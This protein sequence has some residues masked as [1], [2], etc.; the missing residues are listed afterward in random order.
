M[1]VRPAWLEIDLTAI[2]DNVE[3]L[4]SVLGNQRKL[5]AVVKDDAYG[6]GATIIGPVAY[7]CGARMMAVSLIE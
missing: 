6:H 2:A 3:R 1:H 4:L 5:I 7:Q